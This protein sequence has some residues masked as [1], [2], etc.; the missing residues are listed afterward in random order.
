MMSWHQWYETASRLT[1]TTA[2]SLAMPWRS[3]RGGRA[4]TPDRTTREL[5]VEFRDPADCLC[6]TLAWMHA[7]G[8]LDAARAGKLTTR[9]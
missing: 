3:R 8:Y 6:D 1:G 5:G 4:P 9:L 2:R 7:A